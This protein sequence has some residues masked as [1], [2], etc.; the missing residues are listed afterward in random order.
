MTEMDADTPAML[1]QRWM[2]NSRCA[3]EL[4]QHTTQRVKNKSCSEE[5]FTVYF[6]ITPRFHSPC[7]RYTTPP[8]SPHS[9]VKA[10]RREL[11][12]TNKWDSD[13]YGGFF[14]CVCLYMSL[15]GACAS[16]NITWSRTVSVLWSCRIM[17]Y[18]SVAKVSMKSGVMTKW[19]LRVSQVNLMLR[20]LLPAPDVRARFF[21]CSSGD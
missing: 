21:T 18:S 19:K 4:A 7:C 6:K 17:L 8:S 3:S 16:S 12:H 10:E 13:R 5:I 14:L 1:W 11:C 20:H 2:T 15:T 9:L